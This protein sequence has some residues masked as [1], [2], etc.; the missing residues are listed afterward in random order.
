MENNKKQESKPF[1]IQNFIKYK[2][3]RFAKAP[4]ISTENEETRFEDNLQTLNE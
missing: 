2:S 4:H 3:N 1:Q